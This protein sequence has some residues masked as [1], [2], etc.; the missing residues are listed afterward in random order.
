[1]RQK[2]M[3]KVI[4]LSAITAILLLGQAPL[5]FAQALPVVSPETDTTPPG[6]I[7][8]ATASSEET[9]A[10][11]VW[12][13]D[14]LAYGYVEY[15]E[16]VSYGKST[17]K[18][19][20]ARMDNSASI[21]GLAPDTLYHYR[22][23]AEDESGNIAYSEDRTLQT[24]V[25]VTA[26]DN[27]PPEIINIS[28]SNIT[29]SEATISW[30]TDELAQGNVEYGLTPEYGSATPLASD[31]NTSH[32]AL[33][34]NLDPGTEYHYRIVAQDESS[35]EAVSPDEIFTT[36]QA[37]PAAS[38]TP[39]V[40]VFAISN[41]ETESVGTSTAIIIWTTNEP[42]TSQVA[43]GQG[44][45]YNLS[46]PAQTALSTSNRVS[47]ST[48]T[49]GTN[50]FYKVV[51]QNA[52]GE[53]IEKSG[54][55]FNTLYRQKTISKAPVISGV[56]VESIGTST[57]VI[58]WQTD[59]LSDGEVRYG[60]TTAYEQT[61]GLL[62]ES[63]TSHSRALSG[64]TQ[65]TIYNFQ[66]ISRDEFGNEAIYKNATF[67]TQGIVAAVAAPTDS[68]PENQEPE[69]DFNDFETVGGT[70]SY[71]RDKSIAKPGI[72]KMEP[73]NGQALFVLKFLPKTGNTKILI[74]RDFSIYPILPRGGR[75]VYYGYGG[76]FTDAHLQNGKTY[77]YSVFQ[78]SRSKGYSEPIRISVTPRADKNQAELNAVPPVVQKNPIFVFT[79][80]M[81]RGDQGPQ[82]KHI[83]TLLAAQ[84][85]VK[86]KGFIV[87][88]FGARTEASLKTFQ[89]HY[90]L[91]ATGIA[92]IKTLRKLEEFSRFEIVNS[93]TD[94]YKTVW[95]RDLAEGLEGE[96][97][98]LLQRYLVSSG[99]YPEALITGYFGPLTKKALQTFQRRESIDPPAGY[100][101]PVTRKRI[102]EIIK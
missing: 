46:A 102:L 82:V 69:P 3:N 16:T 91:P 42:S 33:L 29:A 20:V 7:S 27:T 60:T 61:N 4:C 76:T 9:Q 15:G 83:Q 13:T 24:A 6:F 38:E 62:N 31:Y 18:S 39:T 55:E 74:A 75:T 72:V 73:L 49:S 65:G 100:F 84:S 21:T 32:S 28:I 14:E 30:T 99:T 59:K 88:Y 40:V 64:L 93:I 22:V 66:I 85:V 90:K 2:T 80:I 47:L 96:D 68:A 25:E 11:V 48:L 63:Q 41:V 92:D 8:I 53:T 101:G 81:R 54:F 87:G 35:N 57:A 1:M 56:S 58:V 44:E 37:A 94:R 52:S 71:F 43:Y 45:T 12:T 10:N 98:T 77:Y 67:T 70:R 95:Q 19:T 23:I 51:S 17:P 36:E 50:Y 97:V 86:S 89:N 79:K 34:S 5:V 78:V 26:M